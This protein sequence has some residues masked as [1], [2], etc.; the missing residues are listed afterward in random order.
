LSRHERQDGAG[1]RRNLPEDFGVRDLMYVIGTEVPVPGGAH[2]T[3]MEL[4]V[5]S[6]HAA[7]QTLHAHIH[8]FEKQGSAIYGRELS[9]LSFSQA[10]SSII[11]MS[12]TMF[13]KKRR[14]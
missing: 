13:P 8:A 11:R 9:H 3:L 4:A 12:L 1:G 5:T 6:P 2:E 7:Q 14:R 10:W